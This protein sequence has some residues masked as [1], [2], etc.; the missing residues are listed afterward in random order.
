MN[1][2]FQITIS[3]M[4]IQACGFRTYA[5]ELG[6]SL[7]LTGIA[8]YLEHDLLIEVE[9]EAS[10]VHQYV[11]WIRMGPIESDISDFSMREIPSSNDKSFQV[12]G[13]FIPEKRSDKVLV[14]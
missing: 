4:N 12:I 5:Y 13:G 11:E 10:S 9:G 1:I 6:K 7:N 3:G 14:A 8:V 2:R